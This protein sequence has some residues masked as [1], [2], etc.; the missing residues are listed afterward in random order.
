MVT[1]HRTL[2]GG[3]RHGHVVIKVRLS[4]INNI[5]LHYMLEKIVE[6]KFRVRTIKRKPD[7]RHKLDLS[8]EMQLQVFRKE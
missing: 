5:T 7:Q 4:H 3:N 2:D 6:G 8:R 1:E